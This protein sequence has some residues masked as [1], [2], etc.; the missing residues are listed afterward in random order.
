MPK[1]KKEKVELKI[2]GVDDI[3]NQVSEVIL[4]DPL[5]AKK[6]ASKESNIDPQY[7]RKMSVQ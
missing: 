1:G 7:E 5:T 3:G 2:S 4:V 6:Y